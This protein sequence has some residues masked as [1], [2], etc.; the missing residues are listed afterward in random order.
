LFPIATALGGGLGGGGGSLV[1]SLSAKGLAAEDSSSS[2]APMDAAA[3]QSAV[4]LWELS[5][6]SLGHAAPAILARLAAA[7]DPAAAA[8]GSSPGGSTYAVGAGGRRGAGSQLVSLAMDGPALR[9]GNDLEA[10][11]TLATLSVNLRFQS[12]SKYTPTRTRTFFCASFISQGLVFIK[13]L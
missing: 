10:L 11:F 6:W 1:S 12:C 8:G 5:D 4:E 7:A 3:Q 2:S 13:Y 9:R